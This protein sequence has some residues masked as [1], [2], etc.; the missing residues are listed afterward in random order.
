MH[1]SLGVKPSTIPVRTQPIS[2]SLCN[3][4]SVK[5]PKTVEVQESLF[6]SEGTQGVVDLGASQTVIGSK[7]VP[8][9]LSLIPENIRAK[10]KQVPC[11]LT[12]RFGNH[13][14]LVSQYAL[15]MPLGSVSFRIA[16]VPGNTPFL[17]SNTFLK[18]IQAVIDTDMETL[19]SKKLN[20]NLTITRTHKN[21]FLMDINQLW[22]DTPPKD[23]GNQCFASEME[24]NQQPDREG[25]SVEEPNAEHDMLRE[26]SV[27]HTQIGQEVPQCQVVQD[28]LTCPFHAAESQNQDSCVK[29]SL[30]PSDPHVGVAKVDRIPQEWRK[31]FGGRANHGHQEHGPG[32]LGERDNPIRKSS[33][34]STV[35]GS[36]RGPWMDRLVRQDLRV[37]RKGIPCEVPDVCREEI[38]PRNPTRS[39]CCTE[40]QGSGSESIGQTQVDCPGIRDQ[41]GMDQGD[42]GRD[43]IGHRRRVD[44]PDTSASP[45]CGGENAT[46]GPGKCRSESKDEWNRDGAPRVG[47][48]CEEPGDQAGAVESLREEIEDDR[49]DFV[50]FAPT[51]MSSSYNQKIS[52]LVDKFM[53]EYDAIQENVRFGQLSK[54]DLFEVMCH[55][56][57]ELTQQA[58]RCGLRA[59]RF[60]IQ[61]SDLSTTEGRHILFQSLKNQKPEN[62]WYSPECGPWCLWS[63]LNM[64]KSLVLEEKILQHRESNLWQIALGIVL[65]RHQRLH[66]KHFHMEQPKGS[67]MWK[68][69]GS[70]ELTEN[71][72]PCCFDL[73]RVG[74]M[75]D[76]KTQEP[77]RKRLHV[78]TTSPALQAC[79]HGKWCSKDHAHRQIAGNTI[80]NGHSMSLSKFTELYP[81]RFAKQI[82]KAIKQETCRSEIL[83]GESTD[84]PT[85]RRRLGQKLSPGQ[86]EQHFPS[87]NWQ[88]VMMLADRKAPR[89][90]K[91]T[92]EDGELF[93]QVQQMCP[94]QEIK[95]LVVCRGMNRY[96]G[97]CKVTPK[98]MAPIRRFVCLERTTNHL[99]VEDEWEPWERL[100]LRALRRACPPSR[101]GLTI[102]A[103][104]KNSSVS[105]PNNIDLAEPSADIPI[106]DQ[107][108][109]NLSEPPMKKPRVSGTEHESDRVDADSSDQ[110][111]TT[112]HQVIDLASQKHG[113]RFL[114]L[115]AEEQSWLLKLHRNLGHPGG[116]KLQEFCRQLNCPD[117]ILQAIPDIKCS[118]CIENRTPS[119]A[120]TAAIHEAMDFGEVISMDGVT[121]TNKAGE[122]FHFYHFVD[123]ATSYQTAIIS[124]SRTTNQAMQALL[125]GWLIWAGSPKLLVLDAASELNADEFMR[126]LQKHN[127]CSRTCAADA[128]WQNARAERHGGILQV[129]LNKMDSEVPIQTYEDLEEALQSATQTKNQW[130]RHRGYPPEMLVFG[131]CASV[132]GSV[133][134]DPN[135]TSHA[136]ALQNLPDGIRF[137]EELSIRERARRAFAFVDNNQVLRRAI[138][139]R[140]RP[141]R[142]PFERGEWVMIWKKRGEAEGQWTGPMQV[143]MQEGKSVVWVT[144][145]QKLY[146][147]APEHVRYLSAMEEWKNQGSNQEI[148]QQSII[149]P[150]GGTQFHNQIHPIGQ[151]VLPPN[152]PHLPGEQ[153]DN[154]ENNG[155]LNA[156]NGAEVGTEN[157]NNLESSQPSE[158]HHGTQPEDEPNVPSISSPANSSQTPGTSD[159][160][161]INNEGP[162]GD[163]GPV[164]VPI[165]SD[166]DELVCDIFDAEA[167]CF[168]LQEDE[169][170]LLE[171]DIASQ[172]IDR[173]RCEEEPHQMAF[174]VSAA[175]RQRSEVKM[176]QLNPEEKRLFQQ[177]KDKEIQSWLT[178][179]TVCRIL[180]HQIPAENVMRCRWILTWKPTDETENN[181]TKTGPQHVP[182]ARLVVLGYED[183][184]VHEIPRDSP[185]MS[186]LARMLILQYAAS[187]HWNI[188]SFDIKTAF[189]RGEE[190]SNRILGLEPPA[191]LRE[192]MRLAPNEILRL[193][194]GAY[195]R[196]DA[197]YLWYMELKK[198]LE[199]LNFKSSPFDPCT[200]VLQNPKTGVTE[201]L[202]GVHVDDGLC[203]GSEYFHQQLKK[204]EEKFPFGSHKQ[205]NFTFTG[206]RLDQKEDYSIW[207]NQQ[208][209]VKDIAAIT[210]SKERRMSL[211]SPVTEQERQALRAVIGSLQYAAVNSRPD[212]CSRLGALQSAINRASVGTLLEANKVLHEAKK[213]SD[214]T[215]KIQPIPLEHLRFIAF[216]DAS[217]A[218][219]KVPDSHQGMVIM[220]CHENISTNRTSVVNPIL[221]HSK[222]I[223]KVAVSTLSAEA[224]ALAG[225]VDML[226]WV[227][228]FWGWIQNV[229]IPWKQADETLLKL[230]AAFA[231][232]PPIEPSDDIPTPTDKVSELLSKLPKENS[233]IITTDCKSLYDLISRTAPPSCQEFRTQLQAKLIKEHLKSGIQIRW[234][235]SQAQI[236]DSLTKI[237]ENAMLRECLALGKYCLHDETEMLKQRSDAK[238]RLQ[239]LR[240]NAKHVGEKDQP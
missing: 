64:G 24:E 219:A 153:N 135:R 175:K 77:I 117:R 199:E 4:P 239:W 7:Q 109:A 92:I 214:V 166:D 127:I 104:P 232:I 195:G 164:D 46:D 233:S 28:T 126:Y 225:A 115:K 97:P 125:K 31:G 34:G 131:K 130:S 11:Q 112:R 156:P 172:D 216:S 102:F 231:A 184:L 118:A 150:H 107:T 237:M 213:Y 42:R 12:F 3:H 186:K 110:E 76:P 177:A 52:R 78:L 138:V 30:N 22:E 147:I 94:Q 53:K 227:R 142:G 236:A 144:M 203:C 155:G 157:P 192:K 152:V 171:V 159:Q 226:S 84:H 1:T 88:T 163:L 202:I 170:W 108:S 133:T 55:D 54:T 204:L 151:E 207:I 208:Q 114:E 181:K 145:G 82:V 178:T 19:W 41:P 194:K 191:E 106:P 35:P 221:W 234:V 61:S 210:V 38:G 121:W 43:R 240:Q 188:E 217:F 238:T 101:V 29:A 116:A 15:L 20:R 128:H 228:L 93:Q 18:G 67:L 45:R 167:E 212:I 141:N 119:V 182:K 83:V 154:G 196:V 49:H 51:G 183:P 17:L 40:G 173:W 57:S 56:Q 223:Q 209:Y 185:T 90:G 143:L 168:H 129:M 146:R 32:D 111:P 197:P 161:G 230:P 21:L 23:L 72:A 132:P 122:R 14:T 200:F 174:L 198:G 65:H 148:G 9:M 86:I 189:L 8:E 229:D 235:P 16:V 124:P 47:A 180:R 222:K 70:Q 91:L 48:S 158:G 215:I 10:V 105:S 99:N 63:N 137:R 81:K 87:V 162:I 206:L 71:L 201:G 190:H 60:D 165:P 134:S 6:A 59:R 120:R 98:G 140:S 179:E 95:H 123:Q 73:C 113:P 79:L 75:K 39:S 33:Q 13:Q 169:G 5:D 44:A 62:V 85:K 27:Q 139:N 218:S 69:P 89:V 74:D 149:P 58:E 193:L 220:S 66:G 187:K 211:E 176:H 96:I 100:S 205:R 68:I 25:S 26:P 50:F 136:V 36:F 37:E 80:V 2:E 160:I 224:M 103:A